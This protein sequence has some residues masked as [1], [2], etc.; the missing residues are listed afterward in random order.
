MLV[1]KGKKGISDNALAEPNDE[2]DE[3]NIESNLL[4]GAAHIAM[5]RAQRTHVNE[6]V[7]LAR[8]DNTENLHFNRSR[9]AI[10]FDYAQNLGLP[11]F[12]DEQPG[13]TRYYSPLN[14]CVFGVANNASPKN[15]LH[16]YLC[17]EGEGKKGGVNV[18]S[19][20]MNHMQT[21]LMPSG[22]NPRSNN[23]LT[24]KITFAADNCTGQN[25]NNAVIRLA[26]LL[27]EGGY[28]ATAEVAFLVKGHTKNSCDRS[29]NL[30]KQHFHGKN[31]CAKEM[32]LKVLN[33]SSDATM[34]DC[35]PSIFKD[36]D[37]L[38]DK[39][40]KKCPPSTIMKSHLFAVHQSDP[41]IVT[42]KA[43]ANYENAIK[44]QLA[45]DA[46]EA[47]MRIALSMP[48][49]ITAALCTGIAD[50]TVKDTLQSD[51]REENPPPPSSL[52]NP[53]PPSF[54]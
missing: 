51:E 36:C 33:K 9:F 37:T 43:A 15:H 16:G 52:P 54:P 2:A 11:Y 8:K 42:A 12:G 31:A 26:N 34:V 10:T 17:H 22:F 44:M 28:F 23:C 7:R 13:D 50:L 25:K 38:L 48:P 32:A 4:R 24:N 3:I 39:L 41:T 53:I 47:P 5:A 1:T 30:M 19:M 14:L 27:V 45:K 46:R 21:Y 20:V 49:F 18:P 35:T 6:C 40:C 29:F